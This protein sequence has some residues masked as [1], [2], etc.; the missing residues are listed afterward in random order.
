MRR[1]AILV[2]NEAEVLD[3]FGPFEVFAVTGRRTRQ[4]PFSVFLVAE[5]RGPVVLRSGV[6]LNPHY[7]I[8]SCPPVEIVLVP[9][10][11]GTRREMHNPRVLQWVRQRAQEAELVLSVCTGALILG[12]AGLLNGLEATTHHAAYAELREAAPGARVLEGVRMSDNGRVILSAGISAGIDM[13][14]HV[15]RRLLGAEAARETAAYMEYH[16]REH[17]S[18]EPPPQ[19]APPLD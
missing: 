19:G 5:K 6:S 1:V 4:E 18:A 8:E 10:G 7:T 9:G 11:F 3:V 12:K 13:S 15:V 2:F 17:G 14:L 16:W